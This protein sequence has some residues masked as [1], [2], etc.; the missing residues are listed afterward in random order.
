[1]SKLNISRRDFINGIALG[2]IAGYSL[3]PAEAFAAMK[4]SAA[5]PPG[6]TGLRGAHPGSFEVAH[7]V[8]WGHTQFARPKQ[9][10]DADYDLVIVGGG[11]SGL[12]AASHYRQEVGAKPK[13]LILDNHD[14]FGGHAKRN[15]FTVDGRELI[16]YGCSQSID[17]PGSYSADARQVLVDAGIEVERFYTYFDRDYYSDRGLGRGIYF[18]EREYGED[19]TVAAFGRRRGG[20]SAQS[21]EEIVKN[22]PLSEAS[23]ASLLQLL[24]TEKDFL[25]GDSRASKIDR[26]RRMSYRDYLLDIVSVTEDVYLLYRDSIRG[27][28]GVGFDAL[29]ALEGYR[30][31]A[32]GFAGLGIGE[33]PPV[34]HERNEPYIFHF[35]DGNA[36]V[37]RALVRQLVPDAIPGSSI[38]DLVTARV[39]YDRLDRSDSST[40]IRLNSTAVNVQHS[41]DQKSVEVTYVNSGNVH[42]VRA[43]H[44][45]WAGYSAMVP[46]VCPE[47]PAEQA[48]AIAYASKVPLVYIN[49]AV[50]NWRAF[51]NLGFNSISIPNPELMHSFGMDFPVSIG[52]YAFTKDPDE[53]TVLHGTYVPTVPDQGLSAREQHTLGRR[54][55]YEK[56]YEEIEASIINQLQGA[57]APGG[58]SAE[59]DI[60]AIT[61]N[62]W[63]HGYAYEYNDLNDPEGW[64]PD[65]GPH[66]IGRAQLGRISFA[67]SDASAFAYV[68]GAFDAGIRAIKEQLNVV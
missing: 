32:P 54:A 7:A 39:D 60:A 64:G 57:L 30:M 29:S 48:E 43:N 52:D 51:A 4:T 68:N 49:I 56:S 36:G 22:F 15:E 6:L 24:N 9:Q 28:W 50:R 12:A 21:A 45:V 44:V 34:G 47:L 33:L 19:R 37:A 1:M 58:F 59:K 26:L 63:P 66:I 31:G 23:R 42:R 16:G 2:T 61:V 18:S 27:L 55:L 40:R 11:L 8:S 46:S 25:Q 14:D 3:S 5:Y 41:A 65:A 38:E 62:R 35:P 67:N 10:T 17:S 53:P 20:T 13:V